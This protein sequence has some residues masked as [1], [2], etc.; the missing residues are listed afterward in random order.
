VTSPVKA[1]RKAALAGNYTILLLRSFLTSFQPATVGKLQLKRNRCNSEAASELLEIIRKAKNPESIKEA[2]LDASWK[3]GVDGRRR[4]AK[5]FGQSGSLR[6]GSIR[7][8]MGG[9]PDV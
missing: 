9:S 7:F 5:L 3:E 1:R 6:R 8:F 4:H 2:H